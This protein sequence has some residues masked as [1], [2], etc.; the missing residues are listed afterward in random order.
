[1]HHVIGR[2]HAEPG[3][4][5]KTKGADSAYVDICRL[6]PG[7]RCWVKL[8]DG[9]QEREVG[10][11]RLGLRGTR[12]AGLPGSWSVPQCTVSVALGGAKVQTDGV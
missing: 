4:R 3:F 9:V 12:P 11:K 5:K 10:A 7:S 6:V 2:E 1:M 8:W